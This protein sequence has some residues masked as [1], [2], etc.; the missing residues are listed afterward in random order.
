MRPCERV[1]V[2]NALNDL[3]TITLH[4]CCYIIAVAPLQ[5]HHC[6]CTRLACA[7]AILQLS[8]KCYIK[9]PDLSF[10][11]DTVA[12]RRGECDSMAQRDSIE[13]HEVPARRRIDGEG[14]RDEEREGERDEEVI[15]YS[16]AAAG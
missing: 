16:N 9:A 6:S 10:P 7:P 5:L 2:E 8:P 12:R 11:L 13:V 14:E 4:H 1:K 15:V 3:N